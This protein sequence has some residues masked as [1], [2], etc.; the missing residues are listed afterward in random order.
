M[1]GT[2]G[3]GKIYIWYGIPHVLTLFASLTVGEQPQI[4]EELVHMQKKSRS[5]ICTAGPHVSFQ[6]YVLLSFEL[7][8]VQK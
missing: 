1:G 7:S 3:A 6:P 4:Q 8:L 5:K 2:L